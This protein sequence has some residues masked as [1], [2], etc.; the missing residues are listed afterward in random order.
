VRSV[1]TLYGEVWY[2][3]KD[4]YVGRSLHNYGEFSGV[5]CEKILSLATPGRLCLDIGANIGFISLMLTYHGHSVVAFEPQPEVF[6]LLRKNAPTA[7]AHCCALGSVAARS[8]MP[9]VRYG[10]RGNYGG[11][12]VG[13]SSELGAISV[14]VATLDSFGFSNVG[15]I[16]LDVEGFEEN[17]LRGGLETIARSRPVMYIEDDRVQKSASL[18]AYIRSLGYSIEEH[19]PPLYREENYSGL[20][21]NIWDKNYVSHNLICKPC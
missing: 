8:I 14:D 15:L 3:G 13:T 17:V 11:M 18:R 21:R 4:E 9:R 7:V 10:S 1:Q 16:K 12:S 20:K 2:W 19:H 5:E 6:N